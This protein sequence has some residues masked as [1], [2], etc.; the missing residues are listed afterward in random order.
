M[1]AP[2][3]HGK[4]KP[5]IA[6]ERQE[7]IVGRGQQA[8]GVQ[9][10]RCGYSRRGARLLL[11]LGTNWTHGNPL[12][13]ISLP[14]DSRPHVLVEATDAE[15]FAS[16]DRNRVETLLKEH[17]ALL[18]RGF[19][20]DLDQFQQFAQ[21]FCP[22]A[23]FND[24]R[25]RAR[26]GERQDVQSVN[27]GTRPFPLHP[28][29]SREPWKPDCAF[30]YC[31]TPP[32]YG[33]ATT[34]CDGVAIVHEL[35]VAIREAMSARRLKYVQPTSPALLRYWL[36]T[37]EPSES[38]LASPPSRCPY[39]FERLGGQIVRVFT[40][41]LLHKPMFTDEPAFGN[42]LLFARYLRGVRNFPLLDDGSPVPDQWVETVKLAS[43]KLTVAMGWRA[44][45]LLML[46]NSR[47]MHGRTEVAANDA[48]LIATYF[49]YLPFAP[50]NP[51]EPEDPIWRKP[52]FQPP[53]AS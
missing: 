20:S 34:I 9:G 45:D 51:E 28:E 25:N 23:V 14:E 19:S 18:F 15:T 32:K 48:R 17:G 33:G 10:H 38:E 24:S 8:V 36:G 50:A 29:L 44:G 3:V 52:G 31:L 35:P 12:I 42:F 1:I 37:P 27:L 5:G 41:P 53:A 13:E 22:V 7:M 43:D 21:T 2:A 11:A 40:R 49:G 16:I 30:F 6:F 26:L 46:D 4:E 39:S 47:F